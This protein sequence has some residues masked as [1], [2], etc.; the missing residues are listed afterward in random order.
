[1]LSLLSNV[2]ILV[3]LM[4]YD[5]WSLKGKLC[6]LCVILRFMYMLFEHFETEMSLIMIMLLC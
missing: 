6:N 4:E 2:V 3:M 5:I 1:M